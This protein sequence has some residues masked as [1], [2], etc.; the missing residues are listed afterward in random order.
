MKKKLN[1]K[2][3]EVKSFVTKL[4]ATK[5]VKGGATGNCKLISLY[6][7]MCRTCEFHCDD[8]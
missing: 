3:I 5:E 8:W 7:S 2:D 1:L 4:D 6:H